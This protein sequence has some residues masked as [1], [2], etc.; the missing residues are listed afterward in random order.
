MFFPGEIAQ[1]KYSNS[2]PFSCFRYSLNTPVGHGAS[3][4]LWQSFKL[5]RTCLC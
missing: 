1:S 2:Y 3:N 5:Y 4:N